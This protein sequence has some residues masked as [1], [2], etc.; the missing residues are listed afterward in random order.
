MYKEFVMAV[1]WFTKLSEISWPGVAVA[2]FV[3][4]ILG[5]IW[6]HWA[7][8]GE[9]WATSLGMNKQEADNVDGMGKVFAFSVIG[10]ILKVI[11]LAFLME[12]MVINTVLGGISLGL[13]IGIAFVSSSIIYHDGF[14]RR[15]NK[16]TCI[17]AGHDIVELG[18]VGAIYG[19]F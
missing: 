10:G 19:A 4:F 12:V 14:A 2:I 15:L 6:Y 11:F 8:F 13:L 3:V 9:L 18:L 5:F 1:N 16:V 7:V 17:N